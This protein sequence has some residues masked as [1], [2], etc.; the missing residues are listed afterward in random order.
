VLRIPD[1]D[2]AKAA[3]LSTLGSPDSQRCYRQAIEHFVAWYCSEPRLAFNKTVVL[4]YRLQLEAEGLAA[5]TINVRLAAVRRLAYEAADSGLLSPELAASIGRVKGPK[6]IGIRIGNW[7]TTDQSK[8]LLSTPDLGSIRGKRDYA[9]LATLLGCGLRRSELIHL[10]VEDLQQRDGRWAIVDMVGKG[11]HVRTVPVP[12]WVKTAID[13]WTVAAGIKTGRLF[14]CVNKTGS[15]WG[16]SITEKVVWW[17]VREFARKANLEGLAPHDL[18][19]TCARLCH[20]AGGELE[21]IQF[22]LGHE[23]V[24]TTEKYLGC[25]QR[26]RVAVNDSIGLEPPT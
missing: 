19:R 21:Q 13:L 6:K 10:T 15:V 7:L 5:S 22:L 24:Q 18:R 17:A 26:L 11:S 8:T 1:L 16:E 25:K 4:R 9:V 20:E 23:S 3:V 14:R 12:A 2:H